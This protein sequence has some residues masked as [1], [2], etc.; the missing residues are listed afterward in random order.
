VSAAR[1]VIV[2]IGTTDVWDV[3]QTVTLAQI[4]QLVRFAQKAILCL[5]QQNV[6]WVAP[7]EHTL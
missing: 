5:E 7:L 1:K 3:Y 4:P 2:L 6:L